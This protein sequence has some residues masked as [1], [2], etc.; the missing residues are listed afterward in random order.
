MTPSPSV[1][2]CL[3]V[4]LHTLQRR[5]MKQPLRIAVAPL[6]A[7]APGCSAPERDT[8]PALPPEPTAGLEL[9]LW[10]VRA[11][12]AELRGALDA[13]S[14]ST[15][16]FGELAASGAI[17]PDQQTLWRSN[18][19]GIVA[20]PAHQ[21]DDALS[22][23]LPVG[24]R[25]TQ[26][27]GVLPE[28]S[29]LAAGPAWS[30]RRL[31]QLD[32][33]TLELDPGRLRIVARA[34]PLPP[35]PGRATPRL[36]IDLVPQHA[37]AAPPDPAE[38]LLDGPALS[39]ASDAGPIF[40]RLALELTATGGEAFIIYPAQPVPGSDT[41]PPVG[42]APE[43]HPTLGHVLLRGS[44]DAGQQNLAILIILE[45]RVPERFGVLG[46]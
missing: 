14:S 18:G 46:P 38:E 33:G 11:S 40:H 27:L 2:K 45:P 5:C 34:W 8:A 29:V 32:A 13:A 44:P 41:P 6:L 42:P 39:R 28:W 12:D 43:Q 3:V 35:A 16:A 36:R 26:W 9:K 17:D 37:E 10:V 24:P 15:D 19:L 7:L 22:T 31:A 30:S 4:N 1:T 20:V 23:L 25:Q 21:L